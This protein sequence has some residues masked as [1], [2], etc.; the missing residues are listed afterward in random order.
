MSA[1]VNS[2][3]VPF[4]QEKPGSAGK[5]TDREEKAAPRVIRVH[6]ILIKRFRRA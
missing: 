3:G 4:S 5:W 2:D 1:I 6:F